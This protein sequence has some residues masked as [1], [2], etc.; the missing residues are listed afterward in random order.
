MNKLNPANSTAW[1]RLGALVFATVLVAYFLLRHIPAGFAEAPDFILAFTGQ[2]IAD[3]G[4]DRL[5]LATTLGGPELG[6]A[7]NN[8]LP[9]GLAVLALLFL[10]FGT[11]TFALLLTLV[12]LHL[13]VAASVGYLA[14]LWRPQRR[15]GLITGLIA[16]LHPV[17]TGAIFSL[18]GLPIMLASWLVIAVAVF[19]TLYLRHRKN[20][21]LS[22]ILI[23]AGLAIST[24]PVGLLAIPTVIALAFALPAEGRLP[25]RRFLPPLAAGL[26]SLLPLFFL[27]SVTGL[28]PY[29][30]QLRSWE[31]SL[32][33][34]VAAW[35]LRAAALP[36]DISL[37]TAH[38]KM[39][40]LLIA[41]VGAGALT[42]AIY[43]TRARPRLW[44]WP[45]LAILAVLPHLI[46]LAMPE[47]DAD[48]A[49]FA[50]FYLPLMFLALWLADLMPAPEHRNRR[51]AFL[52]LLMLL[53]LPQTYLAGHNRAA[54]AERV[55]RLGCEINGLLAKMP[56]G[57]DVV[58]LAAPTNAKL[59]ESAFLAGQYREPFPR[60]IRYRLLMGGRLYPAARNTSLGR[61]FQSWVRL[62][63]SEQ[64]R[65]LGFAE[66]GR[67]MTDLTDL[68]RARIRL[69]EDVIRRDGR[70]T[71]RWPLI[72]E[73]SIN[74]WPSGECGE[75]PLDPDDTAW[76][77]EGFF[78]RLH[79]HLGR[80]PF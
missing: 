55:N 31:S 50:A 67:S 48:N 23:T 76:F 1:R 24:D 11:S 4:L 73:K 46:S 19:T 71:T 64:N 72:D 16:A 8:M 53:F 35:A 22:L 28:A 3:L 36:F 6:F 20:V 15:T 62:P 12:L 10:L 54:R 40:F 78:F 27:G 41:L 61:Q 47:P 2:M 59:I 39:G 14:H 5:P 29:I 80:L 26:G 75:T 18:T 74:L 77:I 70:A 9:L 7:L 58:F 44:I 60:Q 13:A 66:T 25:G 38:E 42:L 56:T 69:A 21:L 65:L 63:F 68:V 43:L 45:P 51:L 79:P 32:P 30:L 52:A 17:A 49:V 37:G 34:H 57:A 33:A